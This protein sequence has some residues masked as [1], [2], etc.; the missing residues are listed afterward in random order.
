[1][2]TDLKIAVA[3]IR[4]Q[5]SRP[6]RE[7]T[8]SSMRKTI[9]DLDVQSARE[10]TRPMLAMFEQSRAVNVARLIERRTMI[11]GQLRVAE[12]SLVEPG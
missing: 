7:G 1:M 4:R 12:L 8:A 6:E 3:R 9:D 11:A 5:L 10:Q 2:P